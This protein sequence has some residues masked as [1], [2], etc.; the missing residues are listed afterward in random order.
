MSIKFKP[1]INTKPQTLLKRQSQPSP[2]RMDSLSK[3]TN[4]IKLNKMRSLYYINTNKNTDKSTTILKKKFQKE[5]NDNFAILDIDKTGFINYSRFS[6]LLQSM[7]FI[8][9]PLR[10]TPEER[11]LILKAW[12]LIGG[13]ESKLI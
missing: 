13:C 3:Q 7:G 9:H 5:F 8:E 4:E 6:I 2:V 11:E 1:K 10:K 12:R